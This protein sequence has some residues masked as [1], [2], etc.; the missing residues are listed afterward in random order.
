MR[1]ATLAVMAILAILG[2][3]AAAQDVT[4]DFDKSADFSSLRTYQWVPGTNL[5]DE[6]N[7]RRIVEAVDA[8]LQSK[9]LRPAGA[10]EQPDVLVAYYAG[11]RN[12][13]EINGTAGYRVG[14]PR[15]VSARVEEVPVGT[16]IVNIFNAKTRGVLWRGVAT[17][18]IDVKAN[19][20]KREKNIT[21]TTA[22]L[23]RHYPPST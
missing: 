8:Q 18:E 9:G 23:F 1:F 20:E 6:F 7:H 5:V 22:K 14:G 11:V 12:E 10:G 19:P 15:P 16:L 17:K 2:T 13:V 21:K 3:P 4:Y